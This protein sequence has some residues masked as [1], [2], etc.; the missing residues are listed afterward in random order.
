MKITEV[1][2]KKRFYLEASYQD[3]YVVR[4]KMK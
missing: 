3:V 1:T 4:R 2:M